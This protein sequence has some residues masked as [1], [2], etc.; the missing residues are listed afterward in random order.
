LNTSSAC[1][2]IVFLVI[3]KGV[4]LRLA[5]LTT[6]DKSNIE[7]KV[8]ELYLKYIVVLQAAS[9]VNTK[10]IILSLYRKIDLIDNK[11]VL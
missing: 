1:K 5:S 2:N 8:N 11:T 10:F 4:F 9:L 3:P 7:I 6:F